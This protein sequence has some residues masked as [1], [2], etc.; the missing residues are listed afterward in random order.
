MHFPKLY[1]NTQQCRARANLFQKLAHGFRVLS[2]SETTDQTRWI[3][4]ILVEV[5]RSRLIG[6]HFANTANVEPNSHRDLIWPGYA[7]VDASI[8][9][10][11]AL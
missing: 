7:V 1:T 10:Q 6:S 8:G 11:L 4:V 9:Q 3:V 2:D 5:D